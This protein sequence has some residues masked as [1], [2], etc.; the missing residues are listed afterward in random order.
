M[1]HMSVYFSR[2]RSRLLG[3]LQEVPEYKENIQSCETPKEVFLNRLNIMFHQVPSKIST[4][5][6]KNKR[7]VGNPVLAV[8]KENHMTDHYH[9]CFQ[10]ARTKIMISAGVMKYQRVMKYLIRKYDTN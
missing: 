4:K 1:F 10:F 2:P 5:K 3:H 7:N 9:I 8:V 6:I